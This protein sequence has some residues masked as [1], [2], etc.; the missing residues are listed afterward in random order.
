[1]TEPV[2]EPIQETPVTPEAT[3]ETPIVEEKTLLG[4]EGEDSQ[5]KEDVKPPEEKNEEVKEEK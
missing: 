2:T 1:M 5:K 4:S 3:P